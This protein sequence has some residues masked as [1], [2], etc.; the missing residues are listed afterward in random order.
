[1]HERQPIP[2]FERKISL[3][4]W[5]ATDFK[6]QY[7]T[8]IDTLNKLGLLE[9]LPKQG[10]MGIVGI[11][12]QE[13]PLPKTDADREKLKQEMEKTGMTEA[14]ISGELKNI[15][16]IEDIIR[17][18]KEV[19]ET[20]LKQGF[21]RLQLTPFAMPLE[22]LAKILERTILKHHKE[23][24]LFAA[25]DKPTD[26]DEPLT[27]NTDQP[28]YKWEGWINP[29][30]PEG[31]IGADVTGQCVYHPKQLTMENHG[32]KTKQDILNGQR[33]KQSSTAG[34]KVLLLETNINIPRE[35]K[36]Q[37]K[38][39][40]KQLE[41][42]QSS[43]Q[44]LQTLLTKPEYAKEQGMTLE[45]WIT[46]ALTYLEEHKQMI[47]DY[48]GKGSTCSL[49]GSYNF[50]LDGMAGARWDRGD[51]RASLDRNGPGR[52]NPSVGFRPAVEIKKFEI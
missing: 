26:P 14:D 16:T 7:E 6:R 44:Y 46:L 39:N 41:T 30:A 32:G 50:A 22:K 24:N 20:K 19:Y 11:D 12:G 28:L 5:L 49:V 18:N 31:Q 17:E 48:Y 15:V 37:I 43:N 35:G 1:M 36:G 33:A 23:G 47:D 8:R 2:E 40:R 34:W 21:A 29:N 4:Q 42:N 3:E 45:D 51:R 27:L 52:Q 25:K 10:E 9:I 13:Y 38:H